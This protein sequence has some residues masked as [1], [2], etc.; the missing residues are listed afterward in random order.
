MSIVSPLAPP[1]FTPEPLGLVIL[2][3]AYPGLTPPGS[4]SS[5]LRAWT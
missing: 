5:A 4:H 3:H 1:A 2:S